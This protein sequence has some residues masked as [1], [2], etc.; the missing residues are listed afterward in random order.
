MDFLNNSQLDATDQQNTDLTNLKT[1]LHQT[2]AESDMEAAAST[3]QADTFK[4]NND[5]EFQ[6][7]TNS[8]NLSENS[9]VTGMLSAREEKTMINENKR[10]KHEINSLQNEIKQLLNRVKSTED[11]KYKA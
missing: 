7:G 6:I 3:L 4:R 2:D 9:D 5:V 10:L 11:G 8:G 1:P